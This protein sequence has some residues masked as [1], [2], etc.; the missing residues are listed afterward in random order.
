MMRARQLGD[1]DWRALVRGSVMT[2]VMVAGIAVAAA[3]PTPVRLAG[4]AA[5]VVLVIS[6]WGPVATPFHEVR[7]PLAVGLLVALA[8]C[9]GV[10]APEHATAWTLA[11]TLLAY[12]FLAVAVLVQVGRHLCIRRTDLAVE[13][14]LMSLAAV[15]ATQAFVD[16]RVPAPGH[17]FGPGAA[18]VSVLL[19]GLDVG[20]AFVCARAFSLHLPRRA[21]VVVLAGAFALLSAVHLASAVSLAGGA[22]VDWPQWGI[23][24]FFLLVGAAAVVN[25]TVPTTER[26]ESDPRRFSP[27]HA[28]VVGLSVLVGPVGLLIDRIDGLS[29]SGAVAASST[30]SACLLAWHVVAILHDRAMVEH[31]ATHDPLT[32]LPNRMLFTDRLQRAIAHA[33]RNDLPVG[34]LYLDL[35]RFKDVNDTLGHEVGDQLLKVVSRRLVECARDEDTVARLAG[36]EFAVLLPHLADADDVL[37]VAERILDALGEPTMIGGQ[38]VRNAGSVG[39]A[40]FPDDGNTAND[41]L[42]AADSAMYRA[43]EHGGASVGVFSSELYR[44]A[45]TRLEIEN[46]LVDGLGRGELVLHY[47]PIVD[48]ESGRIAGAEALVRWQHPEQGLLGPAEFIPVAEQSDL[49]STIGR[50]VIVE[51]CEELARWSSA[52]IHDRYIAVNVSGRQFRHDLVSHVTAAL[53]DTGVDPGRL[54]LEITESAAVDDLDCVAGCLREL[55]ALGVRA[56]IDDF[57]TGYCGLQ[58]LGD[59]PVS[60]LKLD[61][62]FVQ[63]MTPSAAAI[64]AAT[65]AMAHSLGLTLVAEGVENEDQRRFL[66][67]SGCDLLQGFGIA[68][69]MPAD[70][71]RTVLRDAGRRSVGQD[72]ARA[73][74]HRADERA[75]LA[76][77]PP[78]PDSPA[79]VEP[80]PAEPLFAP[81]D[82]SVVSIGST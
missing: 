70:A 32:D 30:V 61:R 79:P 38:R 82:D 71:L 59:L 74:E 17:A 11:V 66:A 23:V 60:T 26:L 25:L 72:E 57:G 56:A 48:A 63:S 62:S 58:Y 19:V 53:R 3:G 46:A 36:D 78:R 42:A 49:I 15:V 40:V 37:V 4:T 43:K 67:R 10:P 69:P 20:L 22:L 5:L 45:A 41:L 31:R 44:H 29:I 54:V 55:R 16:W 80:A 76:A 2:V 8:G 34:V 7:V 14:V 77:R 50:H 65:I 39:V 12:P 1:P 33:V 47:Q 64:V 9:G 13:A 35:D 68:R 21:P 24:V 73:D 18:S 28:L 6:T 27:T 51:A 81:V 75:A 52:G